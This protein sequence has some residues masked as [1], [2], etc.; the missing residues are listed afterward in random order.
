MKRYLSNVLNGPVGEY[1]LA[2][3]VDERDRR[4]RTEGRERVGKELL[5]QSMSGNVT[6][7]GR[8]EAW[9]KYSTTR[10]EFL[11]RADRILSALLGEGVKP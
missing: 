3:E 8:D 10:N 5:L 4:L 6:E 2:S 9:A 11:A 7:S 1:Y